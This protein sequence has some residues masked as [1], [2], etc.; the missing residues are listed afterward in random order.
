MLTHLE[1]TSRH[2]HAGG[3]EYMALAGG[4]EYMTP[5]ALDVGAVEEPVALERDGLA[6]AHVRVPGQA[7]RPRQAGRQAGRDF[8]M[9]RPLSHHCTHRHEWHRSSKISNDDGS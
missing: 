2:S 5:D 8:G 7:Q 1:H 3:M 4:M 9:P 6:A